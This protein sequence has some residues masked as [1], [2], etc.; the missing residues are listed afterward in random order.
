MN[1]MLDILFT[2][3][4]ELIIKIYPFY[5]INRVVFSSYLIHMYFRLILIIFINFRLFPLNSYLES[6]I[7]CLMFFKFVVYNSESLIKVQEKTVKQ[8]KMDGVM[9]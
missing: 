5:L 2:V 4:I 3:S 8:G 1:D 7:N 6:Y 9:D